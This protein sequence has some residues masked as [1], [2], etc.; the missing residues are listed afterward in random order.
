MTTTEHP[1]VTELVWLD[2]AKL[3][4]DPD[5][6]RG[7]LRYIEA[8]AETMKDGVGVLEP[9]TFREVPSEN[10]QGPTLVIVRGHRRRDAA[11]LAG[12]SVVPCQPEGLAESDRARAV[13]RMIENQ[14][15]DDFSPVEEA[16]GV[17]QLLDLG[18]TEEE[19]SSSLALP[20]ARVSASA[21]IGGSPVAS[22]VAEKHDLS[23]DVAL[24]LAEFD[25]DRDVVV[26]LTKVA[27]QDP[28]RFEHA[29][30]R[31][32]KQREDAAVIAAGA[33]KW[34]KKG[35]KILSYE[36]WSAVVNDGKSARLGHL[37]LDPKDKTNPMTPRAH[38][39]CP[40]RAVHLAVGWNGKLQT[41]ELCLD[42]V[43]NGHVTISG[44]AS[45]SSGAARA[46][47]AVSDAAA[48]KATAE[49]RLH[50]AGINASRAAE[51]V[52]RTF[53][54]GLL[55]RRTPPKGTLKFAV[56]DLMTDR[57]LDPNVEIYCALTGVEKG[58]KWNP[59][60]PAQQKYTHGLTEAQLPLALLSRVA[61]DIETG[62]E[63]R[64]WNPAS[65]VKARRK[66]Y[67]SLLI[68]AGYTPST[69]ER[70]GTFGTNVDQ[71]LVEAAAL[72]ETAKAM[73]AA[74]PAAKEAPARRATSASEATRKALSGRVPAT[75]RAAKKRAVRRAPA[76]PRP[77]AN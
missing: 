17:Q 44:A 1:L 39:K 8:L 29:A 19:I 28:G 49:R 24:V 65:D 68:A 50:L 13:K 22:A 45:A 3:Q 37:R 66:A 32:R 10:G 71:V 58:G 15:R 60:G 41:E 5:N 16:R 70:A 14:A 55:Q 51:V 53:V 11:I 4:P 46:K 33:E 59:L 27:V 74:S 63:P 9:I 73:K 40:G 54:K 76:R 38:A 25:D 42:Y 56:E 57:R 67:L 20:A 47:P 31:V 6:P 35:H 2:P 34:D 18:M 72:K 69:V 61:A 26:S 21:R 36:E 52:R 30:S 43:A 64:T 77:S 23:F 62:W 7:P 12:L 48:E 75:R